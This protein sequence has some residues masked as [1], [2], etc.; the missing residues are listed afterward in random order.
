MKGGVI[1]ATTLTDGIA[2]L[3]AGSLTA[4]SATVNVL[5]ANVITDGVGT[6]QNGVLSGVTLGALQEIRLAG[7]WKIVASD[8]QLSIVHTSDGGKTYTEQYIINATGTT[9]FAP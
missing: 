4:D 7:G 3:S 9:V 2:K 6:L 1:T 5:T 8:S